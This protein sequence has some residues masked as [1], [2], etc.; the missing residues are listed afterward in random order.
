MMKGFYFILCSFLA[1]FTTQAQN[2]VTLVEALTSSTSP[3][4][5][6]ANQN[7]ENILSSGQNESNTVLLKYQM[8]FPGDGDSYF[9][10]D[11][12]NRAFALYADTINGFP[13]VPVPAVIL[14]GQT[15]MNTNALTNTDVATALQNAPKAT[16]SGVYSVD[17]VAQTVDITVDMDALVNIPNGSSVRLFM[18]IFE[19]E[20]TGN[21]GT[22]GETSFQHVF[23]SFVGGNLSGEALPGMVA[24][25][26]YQWSGTH[27]FPGN[28]RLP[29]DASNPINNA[30]EHSV[31]EFSDL[32]VAI[33]VQ[34]TDTKEVYQATYALPGTAGLNE[35]IPSIASAELYPNPSS[36][37]TT[38]A[39]QSTEMQDVTLELINAQGQIIST[40]TLNDVPAGRTTHA[41][42]TSDLANGMYTVR[43]SSDNGLVSKRLVVQH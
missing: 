27:T 34:D 13:A 26:A 20:T 39:I 24:G 8:S 36:T 11:A 23:K 6:S 29:A 17:A 35:N 19:Y 41:L 4:C 18:A 12:L 5:L 16:I 32:G 10:P 15:K 14:D 38:L 37:H 42:N 9:V 31:E 22:N 30:V 40:E 43:I 1:V 3:G 21:V 33:W 7:L 25:E 28:Y 2:R